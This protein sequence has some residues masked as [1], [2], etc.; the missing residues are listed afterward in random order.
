MARDGINL[1]NEI[2]G[3]AGERNSMALQTLQFLV[4]EEKKKTSLLL[5][6]IFNT[7]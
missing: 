5:T 1:R 6:R 7:G 4:Q 2:E 3:G